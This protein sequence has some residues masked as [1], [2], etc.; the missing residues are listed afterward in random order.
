MT[1]HKK[2]PLLPIKNI[3]V[4]PKSIIP[5]IVGR[6]SSVKAVEEALKDQK[7]I[8]VTAQKSP[9]TEHPEIKD[10]F[11]HGTKATILQVMRMPNNALKILIEGESR[12]TITNFEKIDWKNERFCDF[13]EWKKSA[14][15]DLLLYNKIY[16]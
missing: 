14:W 13:A 9:D 16:N 12:A 2:I 1:D 15:I 7:S 4:L 3:V 6:A 11:I 10:V 5:V 8:F